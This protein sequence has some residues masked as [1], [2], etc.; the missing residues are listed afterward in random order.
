[1]SS[2]KQQSKIG[3]RSG[4]P[5][6]RRNSKVATVMKEFSKGDLKS[7]SGQKVK[8]PAQ[9]KAIAMSESGQSKRRR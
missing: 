4:P 5:D 9:A 3:K 1:M 8:N 7:S 6:A 2:K